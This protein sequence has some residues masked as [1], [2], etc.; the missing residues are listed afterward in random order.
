[1]VTLA[2]T[3]KFAPE[4]IGQELHILVSTSHYNKTY[5]INNLQQVVDTDGSLS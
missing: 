4:I 3:D 1:M 2:I 5:N